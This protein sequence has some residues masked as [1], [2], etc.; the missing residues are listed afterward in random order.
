[1]AA[2]LSHTS[3]FSPTT[4][5]TRLRTLLHFK[6]SPYPTLCSR[7]PHYT[8][9]HIPNPNYIRIFDTTLRDG[10]QSPGATIEKLRIARHLAKLGVDVIEA[11]FPASSEADLEA[12]GNNS[13]NNNVAREGEDGH[14]PVICGLAR[15]NKSDIDRAWEARGIRGYIRLLRLVRYI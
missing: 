3:T 6:P 7:R 2:S 4:T 9:N 11:G 12:V 13:N 10:E 1:M 14:V 15:C 5:T 8:P